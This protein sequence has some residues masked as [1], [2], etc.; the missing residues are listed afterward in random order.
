MPSLPSR[1]AEN[2]EFASS[3]KDLAAT[4]TVVTGTHRKDQ[5]MNFR[6]LVERRTGHMRAQVKWPSDQG[7]QNGV[8]TDG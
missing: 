6:S 3:K 4:L 8:E 7:D 5:T 1:C 2:A